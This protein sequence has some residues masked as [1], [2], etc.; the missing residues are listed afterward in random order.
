MKRV[1][2][3]FIAFTVSVITP[4]AHADTLSAG[5]GVGL[6]K[7]SPSGTLNNINIKQ[8]AGLG[9]ENNSY[10]W[11]YINHPLPFVP[12]VRIERID[13][14]YSG[15]GTVSSFLDTSFNG[16][17]TH[18]RMTLDQTDALLYWGFS[19]PLIRFDYGLGAKQVSGD[20]TI[21]DINSNS[22]HQSLNE[23]LPIGYLSGQLSLP[24]L[25]ITLSADTKTL[26]SRFND[27]TFKARY[28]IT[29][30][31]LKLGAEAGYRTQIIN[32]NDINNLNIDMKIDGYFAGITLVF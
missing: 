3:G 5:F 14:S 19:L 27:T 10:A 21:T 15:T 1:S 29:T 2:V 16:N 28:D 32:S 8:D 31:G 26:R 20:V 30:F 13:Q 9:T 7:T 23:T 6:W 25:P 12:N 17:E 4:L 22:S 24:S 11:A 18:T